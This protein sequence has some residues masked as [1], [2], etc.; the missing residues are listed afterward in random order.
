ML[1]VSCC[2]N[3]VFN[4]DDALDNIK[5]GKPLAKTNKKEKPAVK[6]AVKLLRIMPETISEAEVNQLQTEYNEASANYTIERRQNGNTPQLAELLVAVQIAYDKL[7]AAKAKLQEHLAQFNED[8]TNDANEQKQLVMDN[9]VR[10]RQNETTTNNIYQSLIRSNSDDT[11]AV[12]A[13]QAAMFAAREDKEK[14]F[15][16]FQREF[17]LTENEAIQLL[18][19]HVAALTNKVPATNQTQK[20]K[21]PRAKQTSDAAPAAGSSAAATYVWKNE[22]IRTMGAHL[23]KQFEEAN[24]NKNYI[25][26]KAEEN[27]TNVNLQTQYKVAQNLLENARKQYSDFNNLDHKKMPYQYTKPIKWT[28]TQR[29]NKLTWLLHEI[30]QAE[31]IEKN[32]QQQLRD[33]DTPLLRSQHVQAQADTENTLEKYRAFFN[34]YAN[35]YKQTDPDTDIQTREPY[36]GDDH[37]EVIQEVR[38]DLTEFYGETLPQVRGGN[39]DLN[40]HVASLPQNTSAAESRDAVSATSDCAHLNLDLTPAT[41]EQLVIGKK[42]GSDS[43]NGF[44][45]ELSMGRG[46]AAKKYVLK[47]SLKPEADN[48]VYEYFTGQYINCVISRLQFPCFVRTFGLL[49]YKTEDDWE[50]VAKQPTKV[51]GK[52]LGSLMEVQTK[53]SFNFQSSCTEPTH[54]ATVIEFLEGESLGKT[55]GLINV[56]K[57]TGGAN[58]APTEN[59]ANTP[60]NIAKMLSFTEN[61]LLCILLQVYIPL[62]ILKD[63]FTHYDL[64]TNNIVLQP[65]VVVNGSAYKTFSYAHAVINGS[66]TTTFRSKFTAKII[67]YG[68]SFFQDPSNPKLGSPYVYKKVCEVQTC[69]TQ[70]T[71]TCGARI[72]FNWLAT[73]TGKFTA[74]NAYF[75]NSSRANIS[76]DLR[77][78]RMLLPKL[79]YLKLLIMQRNQELEYP[80]TLALA[81][82]AARETYSGVFGTPPAESKSPNTRSADAILN[83]TDLV[84]ALLAI[85]NTRPRH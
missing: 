53:K 82:C 29:R 8:R 20:Q 44:V 54:I 32:L 66:G 80:V 74:N 42:L 45:Y 61:E 13:A 9:L 18:Q 23:K 68:R 26:R 37:D 62:M 48:L 27:S 85:L 19:A 22:Q 84:V 24:K 46:S 34:D 56:N 41:M 15:E 52:K 6:P 64:H 3:L 75:I 7:T 73:P 55:W 67:D 63:E 1:A 51:V 76:H 49:K 35:H 31:H 65:V 58:S 71:G 11:A 47:S 30:N 28:Q 69:N 70:Q 79:Q 10:L 17:T 83:V 4:S 81:A 57:R 2:E 12:A 78:M 21:N 16:S 40:A 14:A 50:L 43:S 33:S 72:G 38:N 39:T 36:D 25:Q 60:E 77:L 59:P 5:E